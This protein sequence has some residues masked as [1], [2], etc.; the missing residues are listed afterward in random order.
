MSTVTHKNAD[1][2]Y[3]DERLRRNFNCRGSINMSQDSFAASLVD[4]TKKT[5]AWLHNH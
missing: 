1:P 2:T 5:L 4:A 3:I